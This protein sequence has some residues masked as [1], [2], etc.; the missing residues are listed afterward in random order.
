MDD[1]AGVLHRQGRVGKTTT[2]SA[3]TVVLATAGLRT[4]LISTDPASNLDDVFGVTASSAPMPVGDVSGLHIANINPEQAAAD[5][6]ART[7][8]PYRGVLPDS[9]SHEAAV[10]KQ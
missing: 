10:A 9:R 3:V 4:L 1:P 8:A 2:A 5:Y 7:L 6:R